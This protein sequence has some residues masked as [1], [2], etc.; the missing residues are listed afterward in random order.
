L[1]ACS[2]FS[3]TLKRKKEDK[4]KKQ[5]DDCQ[6][7]VLPGS[8][9]CGGMTCDVYVFSVSDQGWKHYD[10]TNKDKGK[11]KLKQDV[12]CDSSDKEIKKMAPCQHNFIC[13]NYYLEQSSGTHC[14][15]RSSDIK[16]L[17]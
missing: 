16:K 7:K 1:L 2:I 5:Y 13:T 17:D 6:Y 10:L 12:K 8:E 11:C 14:I 9:C 4:C 15:P 3:K